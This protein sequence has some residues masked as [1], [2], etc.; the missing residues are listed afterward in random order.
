MSWS[1]RSSWYDVFAGG[2]GIIYPEWFINVD[3]YYLAYLKTLWD[4]GEV[5]VLTQ[6][7]AIHMT[8]LIKE[9]SYHRVIQNGNV[10]SLS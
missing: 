10:I 3:T 7:E 6:N 1:R 5:T 4:N 8:A 2:I 9:H